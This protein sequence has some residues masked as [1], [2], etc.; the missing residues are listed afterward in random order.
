[1]RIDVALAAGL[2]RD[3]ILPAIGTPQAHVQ[4][5]FRI[6]LAAVATWEKA[7]REVIVPAY[8]RSLSGLVLD[9][10]A[11]L[12]LEISRI[13]PI[14]I[15]RRPIEDWARDTSAWHMRRFAENLR[16]STSIDIGPFLPAM[17]TNE[18]IAQATARNVA[19]I[20]SVSEE[21]R[22]KISDIVIR[23]LSERQPSR[24]VA[25]QISDVTGF[26]RDRS[27]RIAKDQ[28][29]KLVAALDTRRMLSAGLV[30]FKWKHS[31]KEHYR[32]WHKARDGKTFRLDDP[33]LRGD[34]P[35]DKPFCGC[36]K[37]GI[38]RARR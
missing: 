34:M 19:L 17:P 14:A 29:A 37:R 11:G 18:T 27:R 6:Y 32:P 36:K 21:A 4:A 13:D 7:A 23:G 16:N 31:G 35:G 26:A 15:L 28:T 30:E 33:E 38:V 20:R 5:L 1:M 12:E 10:A 3:A 24:A 2:R 25:R 22:A 9:D 8:E